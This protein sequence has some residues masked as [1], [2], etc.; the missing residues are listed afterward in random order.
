MIK[1]N[2]D[3]VVLTD[4]LAIVDKFSL[5]FSRNSTFSFK[6]LFSYF[7]SSFSANSLLY[8]SLSKSSSFIFFMQASARIICIL[9]FKC[10]LKF[11]LLFVSKKHVSPYYYNIF[12]F[13]IYFICNLYRFCNFLAFF[14][15]KVAK[16]HVL[17]IS[18]CI[19]L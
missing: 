11:D 10:L 8:F 3:W 19:F 9:V 14:L 7:N 17:L 15:Q 12:Y 4:V 13:Y 2:A 1:V 5:F 18:F 6:N 16:K